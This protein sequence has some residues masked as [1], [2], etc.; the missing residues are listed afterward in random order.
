M[1]TDKS[2]MHPSS[3]DLD[4]ILVGLDLGMHIN[5]AIHF[6]LNMLRRTILVNDSVWAPGVIRP[7]PPLSF[8]SELDLHASPV[9]RQPGHCF[10]VA[11]QQLLPSLDFVLSQ[12]RTSG[13]V[14]KQ[15]VIGRL[16]IFQQSFDRSVFNA[17]ERV[18]TNHTGE[19]LGYQLLSDAAPQRVQTFDLASLDRKL[20]A[21]FGQPTV[22]ELPGRLALL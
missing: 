8:L 7:L 16:L 19:A 10:L 22:K 13:H 18:R 12:S 21:S 14:A 20:A 2:V 11:S 1:R 6:S 3:F 15:H 5:E 17:L 9:Q 4:G